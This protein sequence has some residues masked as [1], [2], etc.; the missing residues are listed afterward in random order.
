[1]PGAAAAGRRGRPGSRVG[2][3]CGARRQPGRWGRGPGRWRILTEE[4]LGR[5]V[6]VLVRLVEAAGAAV[7]SV[8]AAIAFVLFVKSLVQRDRHGFVRVRL[9][10]GRFLA[11]GLEFQLASDVLRTAVAPSFAEIGQL[12]AI[13]AIRTGLNYFLAE[14][15][16]RGAAPARGRGR[17]PARPRRRRAA[18][19]R[20]AHRER[21][22]G[23]PGPGGSRGGPGRRRR[24][25]APRRGARRDRRAARL[26][27]RR[28]PAPARRPRRA[29]RACSRR[30][31]WSPSGTSSRSV[32]PRGPSPDVRRDAHGP[33]HH[34]ARVR[35]DAQRAQRAAA[36]DQ[37]RL[38]DDAPVPVLAR[39][40]ASSS[41]SSTAVRPMQLAR[42]THG[43]QRDHRGAA[44]SAMSS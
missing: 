34:R 44:R 2:P 24:G 7:I 20:A 33:R 15:D 32:W 25:G 4:L 14:G 21:R 5:V 18:A 12:A 31:W 38:E 42:P 39:P 41:T 43:G 8:G 30:R 23:H 9:L 22:P 35:A 29:G 37:L 26:P 28:R 3:S 1:M 40:T 17:R 11:L 6:A 16:R 19:A 27:P 13:A 36:R 10:L